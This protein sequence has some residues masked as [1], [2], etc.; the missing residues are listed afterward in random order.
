MGVTVHFPATERLALQ[1]TAVFW[2]AATLA[3]YL[4]HL[5]W[6]HRFLRLDTKEWYT[7]TAKQAEKGLAKDMQP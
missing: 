4:K 3:Q 1:Y 7:L 5:R 2:N 6:A